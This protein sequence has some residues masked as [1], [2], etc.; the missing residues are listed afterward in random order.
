MLGDLQKM[1]SVLA[2]RKKS[3]ILIGIFDF[4]I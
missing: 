1:H 3:G 4:G 2:S